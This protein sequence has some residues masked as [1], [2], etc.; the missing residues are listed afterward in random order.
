MASSPHP[1]EHVDESCDEGYS[2][3]D[4]LVGFKSALYERL[5][6]VKAAGFFATAGRC[7]TISRPALDVKGYGLVR[8]PLTE[9]IAKVIINV[10]HQA[11]FGKGILQL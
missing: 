8:L 6:Q 3:D 11:P 7:S 1:N 9:N 2:S 4:N 5:D 10:C